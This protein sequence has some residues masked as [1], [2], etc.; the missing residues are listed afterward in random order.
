MKPK[1]T[2]EQ[3]EWIDSRPEKIKEV[4]KILPMQG[5]YRGKDG[6]GHYTLHS[7]DENLDG[8]VTLTVNRIA[9]PFMPIA[10][11]VFGFKP[12]DLKYCGCLVAENN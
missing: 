1:Y 7:Y 4:I 5:C 10:Y 3:Q 6:N 8:T 9:E 11:K 2:K 12:S